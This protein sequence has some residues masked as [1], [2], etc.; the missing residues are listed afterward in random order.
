VRHLGAALVALLA[1]APSAPA[2]PKRPVKL[3]AVAR[4]E[5]AVLVTWR[6]RSRAARPQIG[7]RRV[8]AGKRRGGRIRRRRGATR[9]LH[10]G[11]APGALYRYRVR[12]CRRGRCS[13][14]SRARRAR[15]RARRG[16]HV[17]PA[18][19]SPGGGP[20]LGSC[21]IFPPDNPWNR[22]VSAD[23]I[24]PR[25]NAYIA[26]IGPGLNLHPDFG[27]NPGYGLPYIV[28]P[29]SQ[30][31]VPVTF[32][33]PGE[34]EPGPYPIPGDAPVEAGSDRHVLALQQGTC[35]LYELYSASFGGGV[36]SA[37]SGAVFDLRSN[38]L[39]PDGWT[40]AD[41]AG[42]PI[43]PG[44]VRYDEVQAGVIRHALRFTVE[45]TQRAYVHP[46]THYAS[47]DTNPDLPPM[48]LRLRMKASFPIGG[49]SR[50]ARVILTALKRYGMFVA[51]NGTSWF[52]TGAADSR[53]NDDAL[54]DL[55]TVPGS[56]FEVVASGPLHKP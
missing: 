24:D 48:G 12:A 3:R 9:L 17:P 28:V 47:S 42:L 2:A 14:W 23:P 18:P 11:L 51:D 45:N 15:T 22:D 38:A 29:A 50:E 30:P 4:S 13:K 49:Y 16:G 1:L 54:E 19:S 37:Y 43:L 56:A 40:S 32:T 21:P 35:R 53:W 39:R 20:T 10:R 26:S 25:S 41:A 5:T 52:I 34:S 33:V 36:W 8:G 6:N 27:S 55:K 7:W 31:K 44:L 46:A